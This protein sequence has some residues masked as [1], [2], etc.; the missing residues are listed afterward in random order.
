M[1]DQSE[2]AAF[3]A[4]FAPTETEITIVTTS[5]GSGA[6]RI[7][8]RELWTASQ[9]FLAYLDA[10]G[11]LHEAHERVEWLAP[12]TARDGWLHDFAPLSQYRLRVRAALP[13]RPED[14]AD[15]IERGVLTEPPGFEHRFALVEVVERDLHLPELDAVV[16]RFLEPVTRTVAGTEFTLDKRLGFFEGH[17]TWCGA[18]TIAYLPSEGAAEDALLAALLADAAA[19][20]VRLRAGAAEALT[21]LANDWR[22]EGEPDITDEEFARR[23]SPLELSV[24]ED[25]IEFTFDDDGLF[26]GHWIVVRASASG[27]I[28]DAHI[29]G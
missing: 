29:S 4:R 20:D 19:W 25:A 21:D 24:E 10:S 5:I 27:E 18:E 3:D 17:I 16:T 2:Y 8:S 11:T 1:S 15:L 23:L 26:S 22:E 6:G 13:G 9:G 12:D 7:P 14:F 28:L